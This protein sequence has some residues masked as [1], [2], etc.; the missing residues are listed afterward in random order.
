MMNLQKGKVASGVALLSTHSSWVV[1][2]SDCESRGPW[3]EST[4]CGLVAGR[5]EYLTLNREGRG[6][7][8][9]AVVSKLRQFHH[10]ILPVFRK[11]Q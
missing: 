8:P 7:S 2:E 11:R 4:C 5:L 1:K 3:L 6:S 10:P 9:P